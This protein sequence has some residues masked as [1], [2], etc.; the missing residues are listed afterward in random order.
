MYSMTGYGKGVAKA[1]GKSVTI[2][3]KS[4][5]HRYLDLGL[6]LPRGFL[7]LEDTVK[8][9]I[10]RAVARGHVDLFL[11]YEQDS[12][13]EGAYTFDAELANSY[14]E[15]ARR[16]AKSTGVKN[17]ITLSSLVKVPDVIKR[18][19]PA[20]NEELLKTLTEDALKTALDS[21]LAM[22]RHEGEALAADI[23]EKLDNIQSSLDVITGLAPKV[24]ENYRTGLEARINEVVEP[25]K[26]DMQRLATEIAL[27]AD[28]CAIDEEIT[29]LN[30]HIA[31]MRTLLAAH[32]PVGRKMEFLV[33][34]FNRETN[35]IGSKANDMSIT[36]EVLKIKNEIEKLREQSA[37]IE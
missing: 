13:T 15:A 12:V 7:Y 14:L 22:R 32:E 2:E 9:I 36:A 11:T 29:R 17:D 20:E 34:E 27:F 3:I 4:V 30:A 6:K 33:Q 35:T 19:Q 26:V 31:H 18:E 16:L 23:N 21:L 24:V 5:N 37:N 28:H 10:S 8:K 1:E 25:S